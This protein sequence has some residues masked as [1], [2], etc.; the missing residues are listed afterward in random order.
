MLVAG[1]ASGDVLGARLMPALRARHPGAVRFSG[2]GGELMAGE[3]LNSLFPMAELSVMGLAEVL[4]R[5]PRLLRRLA[6]T[7]SFARQQRPDAVVTIDAPGFSLRLA[8]RLRKSGLPRIHYVA[9]QVWAWRPGRARHIARTIDHLLALLPFEP[10]FFE[11]YGLPCTFVGHPVVEN[12]L[13]SAGEARAFRDRHGIPPHAPVV[14]TLPG[15]RHSEISRH[16]PVFGAGLKQLAQRWPGLHAVVVTVAPIEQEVRDAAAQWQ[17]PVTVTS[18]R[19]RRF[20][21]FGASDIALAASGTASLEL[22]IAGVPSVIAYRTSLLTGA[23]VR[24]LLNVKFIALPNILA[25]RQIMPEL[26]QEHCTADK[27][28]TALDD[29]LADDHARARQ[30]QALGE[31]AH[32]L[33]AGGP[34]PSSR[35]A[36]AVLEVVQRFQSKPIEG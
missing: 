4:P 9:P 24:P 33:G 29:L 27:L 26:I 16:L 23:M 1:E 32:K 34:A 25:D 10:K 15:S 28:A 21:A 36:D 35:A 7:A 3:G 14:A 13:P 2:V 17:L 11:G 5:M 6:E 8:K 18:E 12:V 19:A 22:A 20:T 30:N 31:I